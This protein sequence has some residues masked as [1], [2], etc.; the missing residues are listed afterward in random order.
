MKRKI[1]LRISNQTNKMD[2]SKIRKYDALNDGAGQYA[3][4]KY[5]PT[6]CIKL[7]LDIPDDVFEKANAEL[8]FNIKA[9]ESCV[10]IKV[11]EGTLN[12]NKEKSDE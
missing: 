8:D 3:R 6:I 5:Y 12:Q 10:E 7:N 11:N 9:A 2:V 1:Y 4:K